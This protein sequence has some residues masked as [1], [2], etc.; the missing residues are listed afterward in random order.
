M[1]SGFGVSGYRVDSCTCVVFI[2]SYLTARLIPR[3]MVLDHRSR[4][5]QNV[6]E[7][8]HSNVCQIDECV[9]F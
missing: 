5:F 1:V 9:L 2:A 7:A 8:L 4:A 6:S 3:P